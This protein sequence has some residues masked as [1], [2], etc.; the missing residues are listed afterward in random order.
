MRSAR[1][2]LDPFV[3]SLSDTVGL[4]YARRMPKLAHAVL[5]S[6]L[7]LAGCMSYMSDPMEKKPEFKASLAA[8]NETP[9]VPGAGYGTM[10]AR[11]I[12][13]QQVLEWRLYYGKL[14]GPVTWAYLQG[15]DGVGNDHAN[16]VPLN[17]PYS[18]NI[19]RGSVTLTPQQ[20]ADL[21][22]GKWS[23][24]LRTE[25]YPNGEIRGTLEPTH[26]LVLMR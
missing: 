17:P 19:E 23:V 9:P 7:L 4:C 12:P 15:P 1:Q 18:G 21:M 8:A 22:A 14:S 3:A 20:A 16:V 26:Y 13:S 2:P 24:E 25:Q 11:Y 5:A 6:L 10:E